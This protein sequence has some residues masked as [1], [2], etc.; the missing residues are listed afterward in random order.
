[1]AKVGR[2]G[3]W[4]GEGQQGRGEKRGGNER[5]EGCARGCILPFPSCA[6]QVG[7]LMG[8][9]ELQRRAELLLGGLA[10]GDV[11]QLLLVHLTGAEQRKFRNVLHT[12]HLI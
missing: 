6:G 2:T 3:P 5:R 7:A 4:C 1:M 10:I 9:V 11:V 8:G 12:V